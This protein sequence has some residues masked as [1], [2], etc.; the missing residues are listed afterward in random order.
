MKPTPFCKHSAG[1]GSANKS[2][3]FLL[4][5]CPFL[6][7][8]FYLK[9]FGRSSRRCP[10]SPVLSG[11]YGSLD[12]HF[13]Q[14]TTWLISWLDGERYSCPVVSVAV[15]S[16]VVSLLLSHV[17]TLVFSRTG[18]VLPHL[19]SS[20]HT[21]S[22][23]VHRGTHAPSSRSLCSLSSSLQRTRSCVKLFI[24]LGLAES[25]IHAAPAGIRPRTSLISFCTIQLRTLR[26]SLFGDSLFLCDLWSRPWGVGRLLGLHAPI[27]RKGSGNNSNNKLPFNSRFFDWRLTIK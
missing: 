4:S 27:P 6:R 24:S 13:F 5:L 18:G 17:S 15:E 23:G 19:N 16:A 21:D 14:G 7:L 10:L 20:T 8:F 25:C 26:H 11:Y 2:F 1:P 22:L 12:T 3:F 9:R